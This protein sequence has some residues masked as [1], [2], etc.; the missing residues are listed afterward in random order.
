MHVDANVDGCIR[1]CIHEYMSR[2]ME[3]L[4]TWT[5]VC[6]HIHIHACMYVCYVHMHTCMYA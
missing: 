5:G 3:N 4:V 6:T 2:C 1:A